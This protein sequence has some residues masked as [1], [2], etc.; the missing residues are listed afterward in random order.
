MFRAI[1]RQ[2][3]SDTVAI[4]S[5]RPFRPVVHSVIHRNCGKPRCNT[6]P[7]FVYHHT[8]HVNPESIINPTIFCTLAP[9]PVS[10]E[11]LSLIES[12]A[13]ALWM[14]RGLSR[15]TLQAY[16]SDLRKLARW[17]EKNSRPGLLSV[18]RTELLAFLAEQSVQGRNPRSS[19]RLLSCFRQFYQYSVREGLLK[20]DPTTRIEA[21]RL[22]VITCLAMC[23][24]R[25]SVDAYNLPPSSCHLRQKL[26]SPPMR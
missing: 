6:G 10:G 12:F 8:R 15:N 2:S 19:A 13:D 21:P 23:P 11:D 18:Q 7:T 24:R 17:L 25:I 20:K 5:W 9:G 26:I 16:Q 4:G 3:K 14:E 1:F 22:S